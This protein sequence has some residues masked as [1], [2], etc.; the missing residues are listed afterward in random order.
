MRLIIAGE[1][2]YSSLL[3]RLAPFWSKI[4]FTGFVEKKILYDLFSISYIGIL[5]SLHEEFGSVALEMMMMGLPMVVGQTTGLSELIVN[6]ETGITVA[7]GK[8]QEDSE[9]VRVLK[10]AIHYLLDSPSVRQQYETNGR[11]R[12]IH[13]YSFD[14][15]AAR[16]T[17]FY[18]VH[19]EHIEI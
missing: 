1:G 4:I 16:V 10:K 7:L 8:E 15:Y 5:P 18:K 12:F 2:D 19:Y 14:Q 9:N 3:P 11:M 13:N 6:G 17:K